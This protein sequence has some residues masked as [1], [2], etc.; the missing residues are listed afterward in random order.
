MYRGLDAVSWGY[1]DDFHAILVVSERVVPSGTASRGH[2]GL[3]R[4]GTLGR[5][6]SCGAVVMSVRGLA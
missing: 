5:A 1:W 3:V 2:D 6:M 4:R